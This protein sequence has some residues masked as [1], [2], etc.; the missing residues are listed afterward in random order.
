M[1]KAEWGTK[2]TCTNCGARFYDLKKDPAVCP[3][4]GTEQEPEQATKTKRPAKAAKETVKDVA[5]K[6]PAAAAVADTEDVDEDLLDTD[7]AGIGDD[8]VEDTSDLGED[9][10]DMAEVIEHMEPGEEEQ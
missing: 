6:K 1:S 2:R 7:D 3:K 5:E 4:C 9:D 8:L 10:D